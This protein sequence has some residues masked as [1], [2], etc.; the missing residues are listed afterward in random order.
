MGEKHPPT[1][2]LRVWSQSGGWET[3][4]WVTSGRGAAVAASLVRVG[5]GG[6][7]PWAETWGPR[8][9]D[10]WRHDWTQ[11][12]QELMDRHPRESYAET[13]ARYAEERRREEAAL[14]AA[15]AA[16]SGGTLTVEAAAARL[17]TGGQEYR[18]FLTAGQICITDAL[19]EHRLA[20]PEGGHER[21]RARQALDDL[22]RHHV[23][24]WV[25]MLTYVHMATR[26]YDAHYSQGAKRW[27][28]RALKEYLSP[29]ED[30][31]GVPGLTP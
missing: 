31:T 3:L 7:Y 17:K 1:Y 14:A 28:D 20:F 8:H 18:D 23:E 11:E 26:R 16:R 13:T 12:G 30:V 19:N 29:T 27:R 5:A 9:P 21:V 25:V 2:S 10:S 4:A 6:P 22:E 15:L 24:D